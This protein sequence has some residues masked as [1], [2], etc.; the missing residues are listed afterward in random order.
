MTPLT[1]EKYEAE[2]SKAIEFCDQGKITPKELAGLIEGL[3]YRLIEPKLYSNV[4]DHAAILRHARLK[5]K[6]YKHD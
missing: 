1:I 3:I 2:K 6:D 5:C 4:K